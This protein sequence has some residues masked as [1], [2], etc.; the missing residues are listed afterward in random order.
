MNIMAFRT[1][2][3]ETIVSASLNLPHVTIQQLGTRIDHAKI[4]NMLHG[5]FSRYDDSI[6]LFANFNE[7]E[8]LR[9]WINTRQ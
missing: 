5:E 8:K 9:R 7:I 6:D 2:Y 4:G 1:K 3:S